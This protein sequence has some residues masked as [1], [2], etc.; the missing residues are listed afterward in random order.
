MATK[1]TYSTVTLDDLTQFV[2]LQEKNLADD[3]KW[4]KVDTVPITDAEKQFLQEITSHLFLLPTHLMN[5]ATLW[6]R[7]IYP[8]L[9]LAEQEPIR[10]WAE[11]P[12]KAQYPQFELDGIAD[13]ILGKVVAGRVKSPYLVVVETKRGGGSSKSTLSTLR[14]VVSGYPF[15]LGTRPSIVPRTLWLLHHCGYLDLR[16]SGSG[17][18]RYRPTNPA[19]GVFQRIHGEN[20]GGDDFSN[21][22]TGSV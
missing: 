8:L 3:Y 9:M 17:R 1:L 20:G 5:E 4:M 12:L 10:A 22:E 19:G 2:N 15:E 7:A 16:E 18:F 14:P 11:V 6:A 21:I 13:G